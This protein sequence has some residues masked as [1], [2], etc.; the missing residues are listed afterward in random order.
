MSVF[1]SLRRPAISSFSRLKLRVTAR[2][3]SSYGD[4]CPY[5]LSPQQLASLKAEG[6][7]D[8]L[9]ILDV[10]WHMPNSSRNADAEFAAK[11]IPTARRLDLDEVASPHEL[12]L[13]H[14]I[15][16]PAVFAKACGTRSD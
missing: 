7:Q 12:G 13:K 11:H 5:V 2:L 4:N 9:A 8:G 6:L 15:P 1:C 10:S 16:T 3:M 14:M